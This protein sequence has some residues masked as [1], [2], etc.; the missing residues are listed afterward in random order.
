M[1]IIEELA[2]LYTYSSLHEGKEHVT[3]LTERFELCQK[4]TGLY[5]TS[6]ACFHYQIHQCKGACIGEEPAEQYNVRVQKALEN[7]HF[8]KQ[9]FFVI[10]EGRTEEEKSV[11]K[12]EGGKYIGFGFVTDIAS[13]MDEMHDCIRPMK[14]NREVRQIINSF[15]KKKKITVLEY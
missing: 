12:I 10:D 6:G 3:T 8:E 1:K 11:V 9:N 13:G 15:L 7:Y 5:E 4:L 2:P 14:D